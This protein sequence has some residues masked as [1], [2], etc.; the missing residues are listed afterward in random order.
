METEDCL[1]YVNLDDGWE[2]Q[3]NEKG[4]ILTNEKFPNMK[5]L[6]DYVHS[7]GL[8]LEYTLLQV[9]LPAG[10]TK[11]ATNTKHKTPKPTMSGVLII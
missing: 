3:R 4:E 11:E 10:S 2:G 5:Q 8:K 1:S 9:H 7:H 6:S